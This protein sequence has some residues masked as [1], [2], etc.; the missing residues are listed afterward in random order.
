MELQE[1]V[2]SAILDIIEGVRD[3]QTA[4]TTDAVI[5]AVSDSRDIGTR[6]VIK[7]DFDVVLTVRQTTSGGGRLEVSAANIID[8]E[9]EGSVGKDSSNMSRV[10][11]SLPVR[12]PSPSRSEG[13]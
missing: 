3:A 1:F 2:K 4:N 12:F 9:L 5:N 8:G 13:L 6:Q 10:R 11:F 7:V